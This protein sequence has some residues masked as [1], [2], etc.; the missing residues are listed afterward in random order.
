[1]DAVEAV[2]PASDTD[3]PGCEELHPAPPAAKT[4]TARADRAEAVISRQL[5]G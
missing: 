1:V 3:R 2:V 4:K 5:L